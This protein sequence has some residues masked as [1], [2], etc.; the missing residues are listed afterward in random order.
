LSFSVFHPA[1]RQTELR[2]GASKSQHARCPERGITFGQAASNSD[3]S[4]SFPLWSTPTLLPQCNEKPHTEPTLLLRF[5]PYVIPSFAR[6]SRT[7]TI[8]GPLHPPKTH[9]HTRAVGNPFITLP[10]TTPIEMH[11]PLS[12]PQHIGKKNRRHSRR[13]SRDIEGSTNSRRSIIRKIKPP[14]LVF[15]R[16]S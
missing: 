9:T 2:H 13:P 10:S 4:V 6:G 3:Q 14:I 5:R 11:L 7:T 1:H 12:C 16:G 8:C 15:V